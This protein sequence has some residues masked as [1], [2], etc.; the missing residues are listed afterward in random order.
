MSSGLRRARALVRRVGTDLPGLAVTIA[1]NDPSLVQVQIASL[2]RHSKGPLTILVADNSSSSEMSQKIEALTRAAGCEYIRLPHNLYSYSRGAAKLGRGSLSHSVALDWAW[3]HCVVKMRPKF[4]LFLDHDVFALGDFSLDAIAAEHV[5][6]GPYRPGEN[7]WII[8]PGLLVISLA[9]IPKMNLTFTPSGDLDS[10]AGL[11]NSLFRFLTQRDVRFMPT[12]HIQV[13][14][15]ETR[16]KSEIE[17]LDS[18]W[19]HLVD[20]SGWFDGK[21]KATELVGLEVNNTTLP[22]A[23]KTLIKELAREL[24]D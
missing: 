18:Q 14:E 8:W 6:V 7:R 2:Q 20:G 3:K 10:G 21:G 16:V 1:F 22:P 15:S 12:E 9:R 4:A 17:V 24:S 5:A 11:W 23:V 19:L 13:L